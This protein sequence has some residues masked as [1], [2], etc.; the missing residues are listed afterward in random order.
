MSTK[1]PSHQYDKN[2][3][4][5]PF[6]HTNIVLKVGDE[7]WVWAGIVHLGQYQTEAH[8]DAALDQYLSLPWWRRWFGPR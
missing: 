8:A 5:L 6:N 4:A 3:R 7:Y 2:G 1:Y